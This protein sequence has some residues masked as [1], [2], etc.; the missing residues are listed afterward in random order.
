MNASVRLLRSVVPTS[1]TVSA[2]VPD[3]HPSASILG[4]ER[5]GSGT[6]IDD[7]SLLLTVNYVVLGAKQ[8][9]VT[10]FDGK[11]IV[12]E[13]VAQD[14]YTGIAAVTVP[15]LSLPVAKGVSSA[16]LQLGQEVFILSSAGDSQRRVSDGAIISLEGF[17]AF[18]EYTLERGILCTAMNPGL[19]GGGVFTLGGRLAGI[20]SLDFNEVGRFT[21]AIPSDCFFD[22]HDELLEHG[23]RTSR[24]AR[25]WVGFYCYVLREHVVIAGVVPGSPSERGGLKAGDVILAMNGVSVTD[26]RKLYESLWLNPPGALVT[27][28]IFR[29]NTTRDVVVQSTDAELFFA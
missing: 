18:W 1:L 15:R 28:Q 27:F 17:D 6:L 9:E 14:F 10:P 5:M 22:Y 12:G 24:P 21:L 4:T 11:T 2:T 19:G 13:V 23:R 8:V 29:D 7:G 3:T 16:E 26:R 20:V 25:A